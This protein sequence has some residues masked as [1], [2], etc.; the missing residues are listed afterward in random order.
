M[1]C[2]ELA[3]HGLLDT[4]SFSPL[5]VSAQICLGYPFAGYTPSSQ[6]LPGQPASPLLKSGLQPAAETCDGNGT[7]P[8]RGKGLIEPRRAVVGCKLFETDR[9]EDLEPRG[10]S[11]SAMQP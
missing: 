4:R 6:A 10:R 3:R 5:E 8:L 9:G 7:L 11:W 1:S 2:F